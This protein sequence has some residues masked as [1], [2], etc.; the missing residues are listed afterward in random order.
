MKALATLA[1][2]AALT[3]FAAPGLAQ[4]EK[5]MPPAVVQQ[6]D[7]INRL[8]AL[9]DARKDPLL[10]LAA[11]NLQ[12]NLGGETSVLPTESTAPQDVLARAKALAGSR[13]EYAGLV[14]DLGV[15]SKAVPRATPT[16]RIDAVSGRT[17]YRY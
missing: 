7:L 15:V 2:A 13:A 9:G 14:N 11:A 16:W 4:E 1:L 10:L 6:L 12:K 3:S 5:A 8:I 17:T